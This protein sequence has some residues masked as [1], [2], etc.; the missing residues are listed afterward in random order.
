MIID[1]NN[2][3]TRNESMKPQADF[4]SVAVTKGVCIQRV[5]IVLQCCILI[6][7]IHTHRTNRKVRKASF[8]HA[9]EAQKFISFFEIKICSTI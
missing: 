5:K 9:A 4:L 2:S 3:H 1:L 8:C 6:Y 7:L